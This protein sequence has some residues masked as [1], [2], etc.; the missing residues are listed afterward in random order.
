MIPVI[1]KLIV[2]DGV[3]PCNTGVDNAIIIIPLVDEDPREIRKRKIVG[4][5]AFTYT[6]GEGRSEDFVIFIRV[7]SADGTFVHYITHKCTFSSLKDA[8]TATLLMGAAMS[9]NTAADVQ[10][11]KTDGKRKRIK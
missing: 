5:G 8:R 1:S 11:I 6:P 7:A 10:Y 2:P 4:W 3:N 9:I